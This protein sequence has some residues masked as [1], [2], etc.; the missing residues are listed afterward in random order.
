MLESAGSIRETKWH[1]KPL[2]QP[3]ASVESGFPLMSISYPYKVVG[4]PKINLGVN[5]SR[6]Q[7]IEKIRDE[8]K[9]IAILA[10]DAV[11]T[12]IVNTELQRT[13]LFLYEKD[14]STTRSIQRADHTRLEVFIEILTESSEFS[15]G[16][17]IDRTQ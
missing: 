6:V 1:D 16:Q 9:W 5:T 13:I 11:Q 3:I 2:K 17:G 10:C 14:G 8:W 7:S 15:G 4:M 12:P